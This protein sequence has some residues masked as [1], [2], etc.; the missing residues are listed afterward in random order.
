MPVLLCLRDSPNCTCSVAVETHPRDALFA[1]QFE[2]YIRRSRG[3]TPL[4]VRHS[5]LYMQ[6]TKNPKTPV[7]VR[8]SELYYTVAVETNP[9][10]A[11]LTRQS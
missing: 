5:E 9:R 7:L 11:L 8:Q 4:L 10:A 1:R 2:P 6:R 3:N